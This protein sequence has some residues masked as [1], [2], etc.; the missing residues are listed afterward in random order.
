VVRL[1]PQLSV[2]DCRAALER[3]MIAMFGPERLAAAS[4]RLR[5]SAEWL[6]RI[7][8]APIDLRGAAPDLSGV[9]TEPAG[10]REDR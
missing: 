6:A 4:D 8:A 2:D 9:P 3:E 1:D 10:G 7:A 5:R